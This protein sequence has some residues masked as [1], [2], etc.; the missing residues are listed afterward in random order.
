MLLISP[1][2]KENHMYDSNIIL[3]FFKSYYKN[4]HF[5]IRVL[6]S[7]FIYQFQTFYA[8]LILLFAV[9]SRRCPAILWLSCDYNNN[10]SSNISHSS[11]RGYIFPW[12]HAGFNSEKVLQNVGRVGERLYL[13]VEQGLWKCLKLS[14]TFDGQYNWN[15]SFSKTGLKFHALKEE[16]SCSMF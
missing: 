7:Q 6:I 11:S 5:Y 3:C 10:T 2:H 8:H 1:L 14:S 4:R 13:G 16:S 15:C 9:I 12:K